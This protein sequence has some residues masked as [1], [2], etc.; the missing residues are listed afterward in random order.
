MNRYFVYAI[1][2]ILM[3]AFFFAFFVFRDELSRA[4]SD[5]TAGELFFP[6]AFED[7]SRKS[8]LDILL[9]DNQPKMT[10]EERA[11][12]IRVLDSLRKDAPG[13]LDV[14]EALEA[15]AGTSTPSSPN[16]DA[17]RNDP[18]SGARNEEDLKR[19]ELLNQMA[20]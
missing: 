1:L 2:V 15:Q 18:H 11:Q 7:R 6:P 20:Q 9:R 16:L 3:V 4:L 13:T 10:E 17:L 14:D 8:Q 12:R 5:T 19:L